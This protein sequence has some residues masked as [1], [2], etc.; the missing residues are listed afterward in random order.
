MQKTVHEVVESIRDN[1][2]FKELNRAMLAGETGNIRMKYLGTDCYVYYAPIERTGW[3]MCIVIPHDDIYANI[4]RIGFIVLLFQLFGLAMLILILLSLVKGQRKYLELEERKEK[5]QGE[6][7]IASAIQMSMVPKD[8]AS[9]PDREDLDIAA[10]I[11]PAKEV[12]GDLYDYFIRDGKLF[13]CI[14]DVSGKGIPA[15]LVMA[16]TRTSFRSLSAEKDSPGQI[17]TAMNDSMSEM[18]ENNMFVTFFCGVLDLRNGHLRYCNAGHNP[19]VIL[20]DRMTLLPVE[21]NLPL[22]IIQGTVFKE[23]ERILNYDDALLLYTDGLTE[24]ENA[25]HDQFGEKR[26]LAALH[27][28]KSA[29]AHLES[30]KHNI[31]EFVGDAPQSDDLTMLF[32]HYLGGQPPARL[33]LGN[34]IRQLSLLPRW[35]ESITRDTGL[36]DLTKTNLNLAIEEAV[37]N[38][39]C[40]AYPEGESGELELEAVRKDHG[41]EFILSDSGKPFDPTVVPDADTTASVEDRPIGG[42]GIYLVR[43]IMD[44]VRYE[45][46]DGK[47]Y[48]YMSKNI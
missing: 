47:N 24:A 19:P 8:S 35:M 46:K 25:T 36:D 29:L 33:I 6:L 18:N 30:I 14:A 31:S 17:V 4:R 3:S 32:L 42:L 23:Q 27:G 11:V 37:T 22:G 12:G 45:R 13:F 43:T 10:D 21:P 48:L 40:Y 15:S 41:L 28:R 7:R 20:S 34:D 38:V 1:K 16:V 44:S 26:M 5:M 2:A 9:L 39:M